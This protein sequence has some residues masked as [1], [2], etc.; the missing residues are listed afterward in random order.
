MDE[1]EQVCRNCW[2]WS[3]YHYCKGHCGLPYVSLGPPNG[4]AAPEPKKN[5]A[6]DGSDGANRY[7]KCNLPKT[8]YSMIEFLEDEL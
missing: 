6:A 1:D 7:P 5:N 3:K 4:L 8:D 2:E